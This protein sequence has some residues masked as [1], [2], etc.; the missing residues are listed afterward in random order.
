MLRAP[1]YTVCYGYVRRAAGL[2]PVEVD[3]VLGVVHEEGDERED[4]DDAE[5]DDVHGHDELLAGV[6]V[7]GRAAVL[8]SPRSWV[9]A[10]RRREAVLAVTVTQA[11]AHAVT[12]A[13]LGAFVFRR[14]EACDG[15]AFLIYAHLKQRKTINAKHFYLF[16]EIKTKF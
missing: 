1:G 14:S 13:V 12:V 6:G 11:V 9:V 8:G 4:G 3:V 15:H 2:L 7:G 5:E 16:E 10:I